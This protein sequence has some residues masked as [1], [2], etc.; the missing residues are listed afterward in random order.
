MKR[1][2]TNKLLVGVVVLSLAL[3]GYFIAP[4]PKPAHAQLNASQTWLGTAGGTQNALTLNVHSVA[5]LRDLL[6]VPLR[7][8][9]AGTN[10]AA[11]SV[12]IN[13][14]GGGTLGPISLL[15]PSSSGG[16]IALVGNEL[17]TS[18]YGEIVYD[19]T[20]FV[21]VS[22]AGNVNSIAG[23]QGSFTLGN[24]LTNSGNVIKSNIAY[25]QGYLSGLILS[26]AGGSATFSV[27][28]G[29]ATDA[30]A[31]DMML[32][33]SSINKT[34]S[35]WAVGTSGGALD[36]GSIA[37]NTWY[38]VFEIKRTDTGV[39]DVCITL[40]TNSACATGG[41]IPAVYSL[42]R[43]IGAMKTNGSSQ[44]TAFTQVGDNFIWSVSVQDFS[45]TTTSVSRTLLT[46]TVP[47]G[48]VVTALYRATMNSNGAGGATAGIFTA[49]EESDQTPT[50]NV[51]SDIAVGV[52]DFRSGPFRTLTNTSAQI[53]IRATSTVPTF[54]INTY[55]WIDARGKN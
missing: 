36:T 15:K 1:L 28:P 52:S 40:T 29:V 42:Q 41:A 22:S 45:G 30:N 8:L 17:L 32:L 7:F 20:E 50:I 38:F 10:T 47:P 26:T 19:G 53:G 33:V 54:I 23:I 44:W 16:L 31:A 4:P 5:A 21:L 14:D 51:F 24:T 48:S 18:V 12:T 55:G 9:P 39:V 3:L 34:T 13:L 43:R 6:G 25:S 37:I 2:F 11:T 27:A 46:L 35:P 49:P